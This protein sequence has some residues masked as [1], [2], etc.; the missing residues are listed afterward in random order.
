MSVRPRWTLLTQSSRP[1]NVAFVFQHAARQKS[2]TQF[3]HL[4]PSP[5][6]LF[7]ASNSLAKYHKSP[8]Y[9]FRIRRA[10]GAWR[11]LRA[12]EPLSDAPWSAGSEEQGPGQSWLANHQEGTLT[13]GAALEILSKARENHDP[14]TNLGQ[15]A[16]NWFWDKYQDYSYPQDYPKKPQLPF[17]PA[18]QSCECNLVVTRCLRSSSH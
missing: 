11:A 6:R 18:W 16:M 15:V 5:A 7:N 4:A 17:S 12:Y 1:R 8:G 3:I 2:Q 10:K 13:S 9:D 14:H